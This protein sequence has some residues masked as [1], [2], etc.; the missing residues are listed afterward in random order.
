[1]KVEGPRVRVEMGILQ[2]FHHPHLTFQPTPL[3]YGQFLSSLTIAWQSPEHVFR[4]SEALTRVVLPEGMGG[5]D[6]IF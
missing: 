2:A 5:T 6:K 4:I 3:R 1:M